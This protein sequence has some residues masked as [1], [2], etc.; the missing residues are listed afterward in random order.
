MFLFHQILKKISFKNEHHLVQ[1]R[2]IED[3]DIV[4]AIGDIHGCID[5]LR[6]LEKKI[7]SDCSLHPNH[8][9]IIICLGDYV[10]RGPNSAHVLDHLSK[11]FDNG[12]NRILIRGNHDDMFERFISSPKRYLSWLEIGGLQT[13]QSYGIFKSAKDLRSMRARDLKILLAATIPQDHFA[14]LRSMVDATFWGHYIF[15]H[16]GIDPNKT[17]LE[18]TRKDFLWSRDEFMLST[19]DFG[20]TV[21]HGHTPVEAPEIKPNR[22]SVDTFAYGGGPLSAIKIRKNEPQID[23]ITS[24][25]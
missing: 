19:K 18:Q 16:A 9:A 15:C 5:K 3:Y 1:T 20:L 21:V 13:L 8:Q 25:R 2:H 14:L 12:I 4:Y 23:I 11:P 10:D 24:N 7:L 6:N 17:I 22:I